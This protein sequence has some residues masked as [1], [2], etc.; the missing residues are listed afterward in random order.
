[1]GYVSA[2]AKW[3]SG[4]HDTADQ[5]KRLESAKSSKTTPDSIDK[6]HQ[7]GT[8]AGSGAAPYATTLYSCTCGDFF[9]RQLP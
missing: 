9:R 7:S 3:P 8:F 4:I 5:K 1:M 2:F 6:E